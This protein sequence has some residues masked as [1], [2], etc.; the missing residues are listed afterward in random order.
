MIK[1]IEYEWDEELMDLVPVKKYLNF[2]QT[3]GLK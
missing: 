3:A 1:E 2:R